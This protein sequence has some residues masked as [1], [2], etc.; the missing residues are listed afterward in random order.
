MLPT[1]LSSLIDSETAIFR[2]A[3]LAL[4]LIFAT[5]LLA[6]VGHAATAPFAP[7]AQWQSAVASGK[8]GDIVAFYSAQPQAQVKLLGAAGQQPA[9]PANPAEEAAFWAGLSSQGLRE[10]HVKVLEIQRPS[11]YQVS[12]V[13]RIEFS[14]NTP[15]GQEPYVIEAGQAWIKQGSD[16]KIAITQRSAPLPRELERL[17]EPATPNVDLYAPP[18]EAP[19]E[20]REALAAAAADHKHIILVF[21]AN[22]CYDCHVL[23][24]AFRAPKIATF[25]DANYHVA[26]INIGE[27]DKNLDLAAQYKVPLDKGV[28]ALA[29]LDASGNVLYSQRNGEFESSLALDQNDII[30][31]LQKWK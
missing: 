26:H 2:L 8:S 3:V 24:A 20:I 11:P 16:W 22:W 4:P 27:A 23:D 30:A 5:A 18:E 15:D 25:V 21:G 6:V 9:A 1:K 19:A 10:F 13:L 12:L 31:F 17:P 7:I 29:V 28:P 14:L